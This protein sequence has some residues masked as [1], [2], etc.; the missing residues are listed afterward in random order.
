[1]F[2]D[3]LVESTGRIRTRSAKLAIGSFLLEAAILAVL[4][5]IPFLYP[6]ALPRQALTTLLTAPPPP[7]APASLPA[8]PAVTRPPAPSMLASLTAPSR[9]PPHALNIT[10]NPAP[11]AIGPGLE[12]TGPAVPG[13]LKNLFGQGA[14]PAPKVVVE[15]KPR[16]GPLRISAG[17]AAGQLLAPIRPV[18]PIIAKT[19]RIQ[20]IVIVEATIS[21]T[22]AVEN[23]HA[24]SGPP[25]LIPAAIAAISQARYQPYQLNGEPVEVSTTIN[26]VFTLNE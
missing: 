11:S 25:M 6:D 12:S 15:P 19:A 16:T 26:I 7:P 10:D 21:K 3:S 13:S 2:E 17:V 5:L 9:I 22:G 4:I 23:A 20:G 1:M 8:Q 14:A 18:Y 24:V